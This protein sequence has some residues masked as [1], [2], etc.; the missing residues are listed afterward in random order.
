MQKN[1]QLVV[2]TGATALNWFSDQSTRAWN[3]TVWLVP[4]LLASFHAGSQTFHVN[5]VAAVY[6]YL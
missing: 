6:Q 1:I 5:A 4:S 2:C 3:K